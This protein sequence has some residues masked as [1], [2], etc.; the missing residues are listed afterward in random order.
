[1]SLWFIKYQVSLLH[2]PASA[3]FPGTGA[4]FRGMASAEISTAISW[5]R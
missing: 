2:S 1:M 3:G 5:E 4:H